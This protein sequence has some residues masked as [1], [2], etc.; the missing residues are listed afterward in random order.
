MKNWS[1]NNPVL[2]SYS[3]IR[4]VKSYLLL[5]DV[6]KFQNTAQALYAVLLYM[7]ND[8]MLWSYEIIL[9]LGQRTA[10]KF[11]SSYRIK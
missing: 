11:M 8:Q 10:V 5:S 4:L 1:S 7:V 2:G 3:T 9:H 6:C